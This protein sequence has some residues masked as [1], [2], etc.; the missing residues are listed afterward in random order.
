[1]LQCLEWLLPQWEEADYPFN[2]MIKRTLFEGLDY[3]DMEN[4]LD[5]KVTIDEY[6]AK[7]GK[8]SDIVTLSFFVKNEQA[9]NDLVDWFERGYNFVLDA[10]LSE[11]EVS[12]NKWVVFVEL[13]RRIAVPKQIIELLSDLETLTGLKLKDYTIEVY[14]E[15]YDADEKI[16]QQVIICNPNRYKIEKEKEDDLNEMRSIAGLDH[17]TIFDAQDDELSRFKSIAGL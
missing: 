12:S 3:H 1:M 5:T 4:Q 15:E 7:M 16:L 8:D 10:S 17:K 11:G 13:S 9:G 6:V 2:N 14:G